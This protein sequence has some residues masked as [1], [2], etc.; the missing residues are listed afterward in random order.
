MT[1][2]AEKRGPGRPAKEKT[3]ACTVLRDFWPEEGVRMRA[4]TVIDVP[5]EDAMDG[6]EN[7]TL[8]RFKG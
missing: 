1:N 6:V 3:V 5:V 8:S 4:G 7:G 2:D